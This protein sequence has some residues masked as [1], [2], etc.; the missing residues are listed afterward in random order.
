[1]TAI[2]E[3]HG[4]TKRFGNVDALSGIDLTAE[5]GRVHALLGPNGAGKTTFVRAIATLITPDAGTL[6]VAGIDARR[7]PDRVREII[8]LAGQFA[9][10]EPAMTGAEN[11]AMV[12]RLRGFSRTQARAASLQLLDQLGLSEDAHRLARTYSG[13]MRRRL[14]LAASLAGNPRLLLL[15][16]PTTGLDPRSRMELWESIRQLVDRGTDVLLT[17]Q[18]LDEA[19]HLADEITI[20]EHGR[21]IATGTPRELKTR[22][23]SDVVEV[24]VRDARDLERLSRALFELGRERPTVA[25]ELRRLSLAVDAGTDRLRDAVRI[26]DELGVAIDDIGV[27]RPT[28]D[29]VFLALTGATAT[30]AVSGQPEP[31]SAA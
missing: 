28:L 18:Y 23:G 30:D 15:D 21:V 11:V 16:E 4:L 8:S 3:A 27:R 7:E 14:D 25:R 1:M 20:I 31:A 24:H 22:A 5:S 26:V 12:A 10:V 9:A 13:G 2:I 29:E 19:D 6:R 17:T